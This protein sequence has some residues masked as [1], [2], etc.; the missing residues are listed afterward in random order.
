M[1]LCACHEAAKHTPFVLSESE[2][3]NRAAEE[4]LRNV[5][6]QMCPNVMPNNGSQT[7][8]VSERE[9]LGVNSSSISR[10]GFRHTISRSKKARRLLTSCIPSMST[11]SRIGKTPLLYRDDKSANP[12]REHSSNPARISLL[13]KRRKKGEM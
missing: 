1:I 13:I 11:E 3:R 12:F 4:V 5:R 9:K 2:P 10:I 8:R 6:E 7:A